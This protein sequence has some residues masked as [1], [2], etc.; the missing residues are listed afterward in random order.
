MM[1]RCE[2]T[3]TVK[4]ALKGMGYTDKDIRVRHCTGVAA[5]WL[6]LYLPFSPSN[7]RDKALRGNKVLDAIQRV[8]GRHGECDGQ[9]SIYFGRDDGDV[10]TSS[11]RTTK[12]EEGI[13]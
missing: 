1:E 9:I 4:Q 3:K 6:G 12:H 2:E 11:S 8:T 5:G 13:A 10:E 7:T